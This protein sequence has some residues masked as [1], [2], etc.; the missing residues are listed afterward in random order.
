[1]K[2]V[3][4]IL[5][6]YNAECTIRRAVDSVL[7]S[8]YAN[9]ELIVQDGQSNDST[10]EILKSYHDSRINIVSEPDN[11][12]SDAFRKALQR[13]T[14]EIIGSC[15]A[16]E[17]ILPNAIADAVDYFSRHPSAGALTG[18]TLITDSNGTV[19]RTASG[20]EFD[21]VEYLL[22][23]RTPYFVS[24]FFSRR[25]LDEIGFFSDDIVYDCFEFDLWCRLGTEHKIAYLPR[26]IAKYAVHEEQLSNTPRAIVP[27]IDGRVAV[28][29]R[30]FSSEGFFGE[31]PRLR[32]R[33]IL[34]QYKMFYAHAVTYGL[35]GIVAALEPRI[36]EVSADASAAGFAQAW[37]QQQSARRVWLGFGNALPPALKR[38][39]LSKGLHLY[40]R[41]AFLAVTRLL[42]GTQ[43]PLT[44][45]GDEVDPE[46]RVELA[47]CHET[48]LIYHGRG[49]ID[50][51]L[52]LWRRTEALSDIEIDSLAC[53]AAQRAPSVDAKDILAIQRRWARRYA[54]RPEIAPRALAAPFSRERPI[55]VGYHCAWWDSPL[56]RH[57]ILNIVRKHDRTRV[58]PYCYTPIP[59]P[60]EIAQ[61]FAAVRVTGRLSDDE[62][63]AQARSD[64]LDILVET[65]GFSP[66]HRYAA[67][68]RRCAPVQISYLNH[69]AT[70]AVPDV[71]YVLGDEVVANGPDRPQFTEKIYALPGCF[72]CF[73][74][75]DEAIP[76]R[77]EPPCLERD[78]VTF[79]CFGTGAKINMQLIEL[80]AAIL[81]RVP[82][83]R[84]LL[85][86]R[87]LTPI[88]NRRFMERRFS[89]FGIGPERLILMAGTDH[90]TIL[91]NY[92]DVDI[93]LD[94]WPYCG[95]NTIAES[96]WQGVPVVTLLGDRFSARYGASL[97]RAHGCAELV[98]DTM[99]RYVAIAVGLAQ[100]RFRLVDYRRRLRDLTGQ[101][102][103]NDS[104]GFARKLEAAYDDM[105]S[106]I[107]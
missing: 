14:G 17:E 99:E 61:I 41:P 67:M 76:F 16:D 70:T 92:G 57:Q 11:G 56:A 8:L 24:S 97:V 49:Q 15:L 69:H 59:V 102:G 36:A 58:L 12:P 90:A 60:Q 106:G 6:C 79:G 105:L 3:S 4:I 107:A 66:F 23:R 2:T 37:I 51:A 91:Q 43:T 33:V 1:M 46:A 86:N 75:R 31:N 94:T 82:G 39:I 27:H 78:F 13:C 98:A 64:R 93:S 25:A 55:R 89:R 18:D 74:L 32:D 68:A 54:D 65:T 81:N 34:A 7:N 47:I 9:V 83:S 96:F 103:F 29:G 10:V 95:G 48:A 22:G 19:K 21:L 42:Q 85:R 50:E 40:I 30:L 73:D 88:D 26:A 28:I 20:A 80:W 63:A 71:D 45:G 100:D 77:P 62:F 84:L 53:Q 52:A 87:E 104:Q 38:W 44:T 35:R 5:F 72:F 101:A